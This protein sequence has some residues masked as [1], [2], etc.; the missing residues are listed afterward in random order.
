MRLLCVPIGCRG[1]VP[2]SPI[3]RSV[4]DQC[5][6]P[7]HVLWAHTSPGLDT[8]VV[9]C[10][11]CGQGPGPA[12]SADD[13]FSRQFTERDRCVDP[14][15]RQ[16]CQACTWAVAEPTART[17][18]C[19][20]S[21][22]PRGVVWEPPWQ[23][24]REI[25]CAPLGPEEALCVPLRGRKHVVPWAQ[26]GSVS[27]DGSVVVWDASA[28]GVFTD[29]LMMLDAGVPSTV[30]VDADAPVVLPSGVAT[31]AG[32]RSWQRVNSWRGTPITALAARVFHRAGDEH[33]SSR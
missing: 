12:R 14:H 4:N 16:V 9:E 29:A 27:T 11:V 23:R 26:W 30:L 28:V 18:V 25:L 33:E 2:C 17:R 10:A 6:L 3:P 8:E 31:G 19:V 13:V 32:M 21:Q 24:V 22:S 1:G 15:G 5:W 20:V 7:A